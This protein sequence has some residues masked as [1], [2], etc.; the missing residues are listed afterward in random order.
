MSEKLRPEWVP[1]SEALLKDQIA[2][3]ELIRS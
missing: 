2:V 3:C 1:A